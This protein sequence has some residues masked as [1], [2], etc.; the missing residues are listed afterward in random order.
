MV[1]MHI[2]DGL[3]NPKPEVVCIG[4]GIVD[5]KDQF[6]ALIESGYD[7][8]LSLETHW[9]PSALTEAQK[10]RPGGQAFS[11]GG[12]YATDACMRSLV[13][14]LEEARAS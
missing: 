13:Q 2:K 14:L 4:E 5:W 10:N 3:R 8:Y 1:H 7:G 9:R 11:E 12:E 6:R